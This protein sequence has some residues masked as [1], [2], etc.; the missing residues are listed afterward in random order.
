MAAKLV[1]PKLERVDE[2]APSDKN[3]AERPDL[4]TTVR[5]SKPVVE[6]LITQGFVTEA[7]LPERIEPD[8]LPEGVTIEVPRRLKRALHIEVAARRDD[9]DKRSVASMKSVILEALAA[10][11]FGDVIRRSDIEVQAGIFMKRQSAQMRRR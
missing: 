9:P 1:P 11:G 6:S 3:I 5:R 8:D 10:Y 2:P 7:T 4:R